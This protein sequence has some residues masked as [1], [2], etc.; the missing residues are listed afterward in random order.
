ML[1]TEHR[2][3][4]NRIAQELRLHETIDARQLRQIMTETGA[5]NDAPEAY[6]LA[7]V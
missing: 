4:L 3:T 1:L 7:N 6:R 2:E 5:I